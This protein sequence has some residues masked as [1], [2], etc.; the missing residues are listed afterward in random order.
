MDQVAIV[1][2]VLPHYR[3]PFFRRLH[4]RLH[5]RDIN[6]RLIY[7]QELRGTV[8]RTVDLPESWTRRI[9]NRYF[10]LGGKELVWQ[11]CL[12]LVRGSRLIVIEQSSRLLANYPLFSL[13]GKHCKI[14]FW[15][16]GK[17]MQSVH[18]GSLSE[19]LKRLMLGRVDWWFAY[20]SL[21]GDVVAA[22][23]YPRSQIAVV[24][25]VIDTS[26]LMSSLDAC[27]EEETLAEKT[28]H[29]ITGDVVGLYCGSMYDIKKLPF[30]MDACMAIKDAVPRF[31][32]VFVGDGP[33]GKFVAERAASLDWMHYV[34]PKFG[35]ELAPY[36][37]MSTALLVPGAVGLAIVDSFVANVP[38][39]TT[40]IPLHGPEVAYLKNGVNGMITPHT[41]QAYAASVAS[42]MNDPGSQ[43]QLTAGCARSAEHYTIENMVENFASGIERCLGREPNRMSVHAN[44]EEVRMNPHLQRRD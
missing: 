40:D 37:R 38:L 34:G 5:E 12:D 33:E 30:L 25:N 19:R 6:L 27:S 42:Y 15:G 18:A 23:G 26:D 31:S 8:P 17:N 20:T 14:A 2:R 3:L 24:Q 13:R 41:V 4:T 39:F 29:G 11:P 44:T 10:H 16:H 35:S 9:E 21:S 28:K 22:S 7:G 43:H 32:M 36:Y 1:Q